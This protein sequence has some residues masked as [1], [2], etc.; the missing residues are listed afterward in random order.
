MLKTDIR[1]L[2][3]AKRSALS[4]HDIDYL[5]RKI[6]QNVLRNFDITNTICSIFLPISRQ[7]EVNTYFILELVNQ[8]KTTFVVSKSEF[9][10]GELLHFIYESNNQLE[11]NTLGIPEPKYGTAIH[12]REID[13]VFVPLLAIDDRGNR[14][15]YGK[16]F[17]DRFLAQC[18]SK[19]QFIGLHLFDEFVT[20]DDLNPLDIP[21]HSCVTPNKIYHFEQ[22]TSR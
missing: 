8:L 14:V 6:T 11:E 17:Y 15:G 16:G 4:E 2:Y 9:E 7:N 18:S 1:K 21:M 10:T 3:K 13:F 20:I 22:T 5:S 19:C 12:P